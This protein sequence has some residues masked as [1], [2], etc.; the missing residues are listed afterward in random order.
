MVTRDTWG[1]WMTCCARAAVN[2]T[3]QNAYRPSAQKKTRLLSYR[4]EV[5]EAV[6]KPIALAE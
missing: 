3:V 4:D 6:A 2:A 5:R 1:S